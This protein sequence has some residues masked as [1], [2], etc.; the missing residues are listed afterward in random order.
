VPLFVGFVISTTGMTAIERLTLMK[1]TRDENRSW[2]RSASTFRYSLHEGNQLLVC[3]LV[4]LGKMDDP[5]GRDADA[6]EA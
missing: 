3:S 2:L 6:S 4:G 1:R 5:R